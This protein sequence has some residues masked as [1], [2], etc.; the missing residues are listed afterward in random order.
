MVPSDSMRVTTVETVE[1][2]TK[3]MHKSMHL[4]SHLRLSFY[5]LLLTTESDNICAC[6]VVSYMY[7]I[8]LADNVYKTC[9]CLTQY[10]TPTKKRHGPVGTV[11]AELEIHPF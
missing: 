4:F 5:S 9:N 1:S 3:Y 8:R 7:S 10:S 6:S 11:P 2:Y